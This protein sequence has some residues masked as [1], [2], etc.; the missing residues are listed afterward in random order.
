MEVPVMYE[1]AGEHR[2]ATSSATSVGSISRLIAD[3]ANMIFSTTSDSEMPWVTA[4]AATW[5]CTSEV[6]TYAGFTQFAVTPCGADSTATT[7]VIPS[8]ACFADTYAT[9][10]ADA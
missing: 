5:F 1:A 3:R 6:R 7:L 10:Y 4:W 9:L 8:S 2:Y